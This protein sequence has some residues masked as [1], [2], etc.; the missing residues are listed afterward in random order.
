VKV[1]TDRLRHLLDEIRVRGGDPP[2]G[3]RRTAW[4]EGDAICVEVDAVAWQQLTQICEKLRILVPQ[5]LIQ[6]A[7]P[8]RYYRGCRG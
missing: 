1:A 4:E 3:I 7:S 5:D 2:S 6:K 8:A